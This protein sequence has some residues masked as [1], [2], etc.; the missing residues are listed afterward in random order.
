MHRDGPWMQTFEGRQFWP[1]DPRVEDV[2]LE[3]I[4][5]S[6][7]KQCRFAG[8]SRDF[9]CP[10]LDQRVLTSDLR[11][12]PA[13]DVETGQALF[14]FDEHPVELGSAGKRKRRFRP[15]TV[16]HATP[17]KRKIVRLELEDGSVLRSSGDHPWLVATKLAKNQTWQTASDIAVAI[18]RNRVRYMHKFFDPWIEENTRE[19]GWLAGIFD[20]EGSFCAKRGGVQL[21]I[22][23][24]PG[25]VLRNIAN[26][27]TDR[28]IVFGEY[29]NAI[30]GV[31]Q[32]Q[33][34]GGW[35]C[36]ARI[37][38]VVRP[39]RLIRKAETALFTG[40][41]NKQ[42]N[43][44]GTPLRIVKAWTEPKEWVAGIETST[45]TYF[46]EGMG[47]H[48]SVAEHSVRVSLACDPDDALWGLLHD[49]SEAYLVDVPRPIKPHLTQYRSIETGVMRAICTR[50]GL[51][52]AMPESVK[53]ADNVLLATE[54]RDLMA[55][56]PADW[57][58]EEQA[59]LESIV[60]W[61]HEHAR[62]Q[63]VARFLEISGVS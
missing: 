46:C 45:H 58:L 55:A 33:I 17:V 11:W 63:F 14:G 53:R 1:L 61:T 62:T 39:E 52:E 31:S 19:A 30:S 44:A 10:T 38:G 54:A 8:H 34:K 51:S 15:S 37:L 48:N 47:A 18:E 59:L 41:L 24:K 3:D 28:G 22:A 35:R 5:A 43:G 20:G 4:A 25:P 9:Y 2:Y 23:Q 12:I 27:L 16:T 50:F 7:S 21:S 26:L 60:P 56:S 32:I 49:A 40:E 42:L 36:S 13:G 29:L 6:L 57:E